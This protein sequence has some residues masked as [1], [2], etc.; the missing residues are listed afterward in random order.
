MVKFP[1]NEEAIHQGYVTWLLPMTLKIDALTVLRT[2]RDFMSVQSSQ[3]S[4]PKNKKRYSEI[5]EQ[6]D[7]S[8]HDELN[9][10]LR[11]KS[12]RI[13][14]NIIFFLIC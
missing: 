2:C 7:I 1:D 12:G 14:Y 13:A 11:D 8:L 9:E 10:K 6:E 5:K 4:A 3:W